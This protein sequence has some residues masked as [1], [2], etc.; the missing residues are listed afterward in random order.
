FLE[1]ATFFGGN[2]AAE[3]VDGGTSRF[4]KRGAIYQAVCAGCGG[5]SLFPTTPGVWSN[6]NNST[7]CNLGAVKFDF[8][9]SAVEVAVL[10]TPAAQG[11]SPLTVNFADG[12]IN[13]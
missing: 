1:Y 3:H 4:D 10:P 7:N 11:C 5:N 6:T 12:G 8:Q 13:A 9:I 2:G